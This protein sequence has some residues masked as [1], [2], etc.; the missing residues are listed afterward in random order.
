MFPL[1]KLLI[2][3]RR[4][5]N[6][7]VK[8]VGLKRKA[9]FPS[10]DAGGVSDR[11][12][13]VLKNQGGVLCRVAR[14]MGFGWLSFQTALLGWEGALLLPSG[15]PAGHFRVSLLGE[16]R[17]TLTAEDGG[18][19]FYPPPQFPVRLVAVAPDGRVFGPIEVESPVSRLELPP[20]LTETMSVVSG[21]AP[22]LDLLPG[23]VA[24]LLTAGDLEAQK[25]TR[26]FQALEEVPGGGRLGDGPDAV[27]ALRNLARGRTL[28]ILDGARVN[29]ERRAGPSLTFLE[30][31]TLEAIEVAR[32]P[33]SVAYGSDAFGG[34]IQVL[35]REPAWG[36]SS[37]RFSMEVGALGEPGRAAYASASRAGSKLD[38]GFDAY[39]RDMENQRAGGDEEILNS[40]FE[41]VGGSLQARWLLGRG[42]LRTRMAVDRVTDLGKASVD[43]QTI[44]SFYPEEVSRRVV[45]RFSGLFLELGEFHGV[46]GWGPY[47]ITLDRDRQPTATSNRRVDRAITRAEDFELRG[48]LE[49]AAQGGRLRLGVDLRGRM[50]LEAI[51]EVIRFADDGQTPLRVDRTRAIEDASQV[52][53]AGFAAWDRPLGEAMT[54]GLGL[55]GDRIQTRNRGGFF[56][57]RRVNREALSG[58][59]AWTWRVKET[60][61]WVVQAARGFRSPTLSDRYFRGPSGRGF[62]TGNPELDPETSWQLDSRLDW[63]LGASR[64]VLSAYRYEIRDL[65]ER[66]RVENDFYFRNRGQVQISGI[67]LDGQGHWG[68]E[69]SWRWSAVR[70]WGKT[71]SGEAIDDIL[72]P[73]VLGTLRWNR[74]RF[75]SWLQVTVFSRHDKPGPTEVERPGFAR[76][77]LGASQRFRDTASLSLLVRNVFDR[78]YTASPDEAADRAPGRTVL[79]S[80]S[81]K[82]DSRVGPRSGLEP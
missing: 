69:W 56:G 37:L 18:F 48:V 44:R 50:D 6:Q 35:T 42:L 30:P 80:L 65:I 81:W 45:L 70:S 31:L 78:R 24:E 12:P 8:K 32:G 2:P 16:G 9:S 52:L 19:R 7:M 68:K 63:Q 58:N 22:H 49:R 72:P 23:S 3:T 21:A 17:N 11:S 43:S 77:D 28:L 46:A 41:A 76:V 82:L 14:L 26:L 61:Q 64:F 54:V 67:E 13:R 10:P 79:L 47:A 74:D 51:T 27:P 25:P 75:A 59:L 38:L 53:S 29:A 33:A 73:H 36:G 71:A 39:Y 60:V 34:V 57:S 15:V 4:S 20:T 62:I 55:R 5:L 40:S 1:S 66:Y